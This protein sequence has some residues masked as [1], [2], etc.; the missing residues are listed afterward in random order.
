[1]FDKLK[2]IKDFFKVVKVNFDR[3]P[4]LTLG[5]IIGHIV[6]IVLIEHFVFR[7]VY[8]TGVSVTLTIAGVLFASIKLPFMKWFWQGYAPRMKVTEPQAPKAKP[9]KKPKAEKVEVETE[10]VAKKPVPEKTMKSNVEDLK[11][12]GVQPRETPIGTRLSSSESTGDV[13]M[14]VKVAIYLWSWAL[15]AAF[16]AFAI[17]AGIFGAFQGGMMFDPSEWERGYETVGFMIHLGNG[18]LI[19]FGLFVGLAILSFYI[20]RPEIAV[21]VSRKTVTIGTEVYDRRL[22]GGF[23]PGLSSDEFSPNRNPLSRDMGAVVLKAR[24]GRWGAMTKYLVDGQ[25]AND[26][27]IWMND[28]IESTNASEEMPYD[29]FVG[30]K[31]ELL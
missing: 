18:A 20:T 19:G 3:N 17:P 5:A 16:G 12:R 1:M 31:I 24:Y 11:I 6:L 10:V 9:V 8:L 7:L 25:H 23:A 15:P 21:R 27:I 28:I 13:V 29:P 14:Y 26:I 22:F 4:R 2:P 30:K